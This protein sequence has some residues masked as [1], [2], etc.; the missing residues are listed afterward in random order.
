M[1]DDISFTT[2]IAI[3][4]GLTTILYNILNWVHYFR[5]KANWDYYYIDNNI[6]P[7]KNN[8]F[9]SEYIATS[10]AIIVCAWLLQEI[11]IQFEWKEAQELSMLFLGL[12][13]L[14]FFCAFFMYGFF[15]YYDIQKKVRDKKQLL[16]YVVLKASL[17]TTKYGCIILSYF[18]C[19][20]FLNSKW[21]MWFKV[22]IIGILL[23]FTGIF[24]ICFEYNQAKI[25]VN[26]EREYETVKIAG[27]NYCIISTLH[28]SN[29]LTV[30][31]DTRI[32]KTKGII[33]RLYLDSRMIIPINNIE[34]MKNTYFKVERYYNNHEIK[35]HAWWYIG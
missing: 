28:Y 20:F 30:K 22:I 19:I 6:R 35:P 24:C 3:A 15:S 23:L 27:N 5:L 10:L 31:C 26:Q 29:Y 1:L 7:Y 16:R 2:F 21:D 9:N 25:I 32:A 11:M 12:V 14:I 4:S 13:I 34:V 33:I 18:C 17:S 8:S